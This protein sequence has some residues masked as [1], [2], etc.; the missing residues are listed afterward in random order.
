[1]IMLL[2]NNFQHRLILTSFF[3]LLLSLLI[4]P[5]VVSGYQEDASDK[6]DERKLL[7]FP[8]S[9]INSSH[10]VP[11]N[12]VSTPVDVTAKLFQDLRSTSWH[13]QFV[14]DLEFSKDVSSYTSKSKDDKTIASSQHLPDVSLQTVG[15]KDEF[16]VYNISSATYSNRTATLAYIGE[17]SYIYLEDDA[18]FTISEEQILDLRLSFDQLIYPEVTRIFGNVSGILGDIDDDPRVT[19][20][21]G[22]FVPQVIGFYAPINEYNYDRD[23]RSLSDGYSNQREMLFLNSRP[24]DT[25]LFASVIAHEFQH[26]I[27]YNH[28]PTEHFWVNEGL[29]E[30]SAFRLGL[31][32]DPD[33]AINA[34]IKNP[35]EDLLFWN[36]YGNP[37]ADY[38]G[39]SLFFQYLHAKYGDD[40][41]SKLVDTSSD[42]VE[43][44][45]HAI[46]YATQDYISFQEL[47]LEWMASLLFLE[48]PSSDLKNEEGSTISVPIRTFLELELNS[49]EGSVYRYGFDVHK[50]S[51]VG[52]SSLLFS[53]ENQ[54]NLP[55][56]FRFLRLSTESPLSFNISETHSVER[57]SVSSVLNL[58]SSFNN[59]DLYILI[60]STPSTSE[61]NYDFARNGDSDIGIGIATPYSFSTQVVDPLSVNALNLSTEYLSDDYFLSFDNLKILK[62]DNTE[63]SDFVS[64]VNFPDDF[65][66]VLV[67]NKAGFVVASENPSYSEENN[68]HFNITLQ[69]L[70]PQYYD[71]RVFAQK[72]DDHLNFLLLTDVFVN[73]TFSIRDKP[74]VLTDDGGDTYITQNV[75]YT[76]LGG[77]YLSNARSILHI[78]NQTTDALVYSLVYS[79]TGE[80]GFEAILPFNQIP[81]GDYIAQSSIVLNGKVSFSPS[82]LFSLVNNSIQPSAEGN[83]SYYLVIPILLPSSLLV[84]VYITR[85]K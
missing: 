70:P 59:S 4:F 76:Q 31:R 9:G 11:P 53:I 61:I 48:V 22:E 75:E 8:P 57:T 45:E 33:S 30:M 34:F 69:N 72:G 50:M 84:I 23:L 83:V 27:H 55:L 71:V 63:I 47:A 18:N 5:G 60:S 36:Y 19:I 25:G 17:Y 15:H 20:F 49:I 14:R 66:S 42:G 29:S 77:A 10:H 37:S 6:D 1:M 13:K 85:R 35:D 43:G 74:S 7:S 52:N 3:S 68:W 41:I 46:Y 65:I 2:N 39:A 79:Y 64:T 62:S 82:L 32:E 73:H 16:E 67:F 40:F 26:L 38:G 81:E 78:Y 54:G 28:D 51:S 21:I 12:G 56:S 80:M 44:I 24:I 58:G